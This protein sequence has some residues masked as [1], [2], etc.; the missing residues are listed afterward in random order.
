MGTSVEEKQ[1]ENS[2]ETVLWSCPGPEPR[3]LGPFCEFTL[4]CFRF[5]SW[6]LGCQK[7]ILVPMT[8]VTLAHV[9]GRAK[10]SGEFDAA[11]EDYLA[12]CSGFLPVTTERFRSEALLLER[13]KKQKGRVVMVL[14]DSHGRQMTSEAFA[15]W[16]GAR[17]DEGVKEIVFAVGPAD[18]WTDAARDR[19]AILMSLGSMTMAHGLARLVMAEQIYRAVAILTGHPYHRAH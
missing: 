7:A 12:R 1:L 5:Y 13:T 2:P 19:A 16:L 4:E 3:T 9:G 8:K 18:G 14:L 11:V 15:Q 10:E 6:R 17:R